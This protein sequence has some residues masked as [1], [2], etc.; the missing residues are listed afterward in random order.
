MGILVVVRALEMDNWYRGGKM[1][2]MESFL[3]RFTFY[4]FGIPYERDIVMI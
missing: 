1:V 2:K 4:A 3:L